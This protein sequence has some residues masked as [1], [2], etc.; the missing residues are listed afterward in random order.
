MSDDVKEYVAGLA[1][2]VA[3]V[4]TGHPFDTVKV[5][6]DCHWIVKSYCERLNL[7]LFD[8]FSNIIN[9]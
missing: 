5:L 1:A 6:S 8:L 9:F 2:G 4:V 3:T 7:S